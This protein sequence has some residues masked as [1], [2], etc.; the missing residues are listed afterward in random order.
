MD[1]YAT[2]VASPPIDPRPPETV[3]N[4]WRL[5]MFGKLFL[6]SAA[7]AAVTCCLVAAPASA[8]PSLVSGV[9]SP[10]GRAPACSDLLASYTMTGGLV[11]CW[12]SDTGAITK[13]HIT[14]SG[15]DLIHFAGTE[16]FT[17]CLDVD[18]DGQCAGDPSGTLYFSFTF[19]GQYD[20]VT[21]DEIRGRCHH[22]VVGSTGDFAGATGVINFKDDVS[23]GTAVYMGQINF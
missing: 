3:K 22:P 19:T 6:A 1:A 12:Y 9:Q 23:N 2:A 21:G 4:T 16:H 18:G 13:E 5:Y 14:S 7:L 10:G 20:T 15:T 17:G 8:S 11:G